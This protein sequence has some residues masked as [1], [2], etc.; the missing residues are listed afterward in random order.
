M[1]AASGERRAGPKARRDGRDCADVGR[2]ESGPRRAGPRTPARGTPRRVCEAWA[3]RD[4]VHLRR[5]W[6]CPGRWW[7]GGTVAGVMGDAGRPSPR[8][9]RRRQRRRASRRFD[10]RGGSDGAA[11]GS[12]L[13]A[14][15]RRMA[16]EGAGGPDVR[17]QPGG[18]RR[19]MARARQRRYGRLRS[20]PGRA[21][22]PRWVCWATGP[23]SISESNAECTC[24]SDFNLSF[25]GR[26]LARQQ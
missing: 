18:R 16:R 12:R 23:R 26:P 13:G 8:P 9:R 3:G 10:R 6:G 17:A 20:H 21:L 5:R 7:G 19:T 1:P 14:G 4:S 11:S 24:D 2:S 15:P 22:G 25:S